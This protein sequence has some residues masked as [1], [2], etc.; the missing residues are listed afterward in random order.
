MRM[1]NK[2]VYYIVEKDVEEKI[3]FIHKE[4]Y[5]NKKEAEEYIKML[6][7]QFGT[8]YHDFF[9]AEMEE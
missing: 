6:E 4:G 1:N 9:I 5:D 2:M 7:R 3:G 8:E